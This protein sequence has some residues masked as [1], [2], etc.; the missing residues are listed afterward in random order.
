ML[1]GKIDIFVF[2]T[3]GKILSPQKHTIIQEAKF[4]LSASRERIRKTNKI[5]F[6]SMVKEQVDAL[7]SLGFT[8]SKI[9][10]FESIPDVFS[11]DLLNNKAQKEL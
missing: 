2:L 10:K 4:F 9:N 1:S 5:D 3:G 6:R 8:G 11:E 7:Q